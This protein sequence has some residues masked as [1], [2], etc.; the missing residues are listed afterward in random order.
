[1]KRE[2]SYVV[3]TEVEYS[4]LE[5]LIK[6]LG[7]SSSKLEAKVI[8]LETRIKE[9]E[10]QLKKDSSNSS[11][12]PSSDGY[13][14]RGV[15]LNNREK[16]EKKQGAQPGNLGNSLKM[17]ALSDKVVEHKVEGYCVCGQNLQEL[18]AHDVQV[19]QVIDLPEKLTEV[20]NHMVEIKQCVCGLK[21]EAKCE[22]THGV[23]YGTRLK[24]L[25]VYFTQYQHIPFG[26]TQEIMAEI[27]GVNISDGTLVDSNK[28]CYDFLQETED[29]IKQALLKSPVIHNDETGMRCDGSLHW[30]HS[31]STSTHTH[32]ALDKKRGAPA[33]DKIG[34]LPNYTG[35]SI[36]DRWASYDSYNC[37][38]GLCNAHL[39]FELKYIHQQEDKQWAKQMIDLLVQANNQKKENKL[40]TITTNLILLS[41]QEIIQQA[42]LQ[43]P[44]INPPPEKKRGRIKKTKSLNLLETFTNRKEQILLF[45]TNKQVPF[46]NNL[47]E[48]DL[49]MVKLKQKISGCFRTN[50]GAQLF[51]RIRSYIST[52]RK[53]G[54]SVIQAI[55]LALNQ[56]PINVA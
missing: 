33:M 11:K 34:V 52:V 7:S 27:F 45:V 46:D 6:T 9:L 19:R 56:N 28:A 4:D 51:C 24:S 17:I 55:N 25:G 20:T 44:Q 49:R 2:G 14:K 37:V 1:M 13:K 41:Y 31:T 36:H 29:Q 8:D 3:L 53:Q 48:R 54:H 43:E 12:P 50:N 32:Y 15:I 38:H 21:H 26:R 16:S 18:L 39:L 5:L 22:V 23:Q 42:K 47:A 40:D 35:V 10:G 30:V